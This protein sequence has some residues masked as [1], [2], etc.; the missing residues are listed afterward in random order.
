MMDFVIIVLYLLKHQLNSRNFKE[1]NKNFRLIVAKEEPIG[2]FIAIG[3]IVKFQW[4]L[5]GL[6]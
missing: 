6:K 4:D 2:I 1:I 5:G 3:I